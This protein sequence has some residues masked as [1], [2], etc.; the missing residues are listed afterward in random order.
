MANLFWS[1]VQVAVQSALATAETIT[2]ISKA[3]PGVVTHSGTDPSDGD[4]VL[5]S[6]Q[7]MFQIN[8]RVFR[9][10]NASS[11]SFELEGEDTTDYE[12]FSSGTFQVV[13]LGTTL[14][15]ITNVSPSGGEPEFADTT[16]IHDLI[17]TQV[18]TVTSA[19]SFGMTSRFDPSDTA[20]QALN[21]ASKKLEQRVVRFTFKNGSVLVFNG[22]VSFPYI[23]TGQAQGLVESPL[24]F[25]V[26]GQPTVYAS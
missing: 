9:V 14:S 10:A 15:S 12:T 7:G 2:G 18:P 17:R 26:D 21:V 8:S 5:L 23:P 20:L 22:F 19:L 4:Y 24:T 11:G 3:S 1:G 25:T 16:T 13:T 6:V